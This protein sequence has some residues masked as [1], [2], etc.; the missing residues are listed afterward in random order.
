MSLPLVAKDGDNL[1]HG[2]P[3]M[4][5]HDGPPLLTYLEGVAVE[6][7]MRIAPF[8]YP[9]Q[10]VNRPNL[11]F[12]GFSGFISGGNIQPGDIVRILPAG[13]DTRVDARSSR[14]TAISTAPSPANRS[15]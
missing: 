6:D 13:R 4:P 2:S 11:D 8:R 9:V 10:W 3:N 12:R 7:V 5:W 1:V 15:P 14:T